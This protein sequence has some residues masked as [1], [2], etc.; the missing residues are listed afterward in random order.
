VTTGIYRYIRHPMYGALL[1][2]G[3]GI[4]LGYPTVMGLPVV[5]LTAIVIYVAARVEERENI[6]YFGAQYLAYMKTTRMFIPHVA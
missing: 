5:V 2:Y 4:Y 1:L 6:G 3:W